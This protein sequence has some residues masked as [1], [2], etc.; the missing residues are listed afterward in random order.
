MVTKTEKNIQ[1]QKIVELMVILNNEMEKIIDNIKYNE[2]LDHYSE[3]IFKKTVIAMYANRIYGLLITALY[4]MNSD[5]KTELLMPIK[6]YL[7]SGNIESEL[8]KN[9]LNLIQ[10]DNAGNKEMAKLIMQA[11]ILPINK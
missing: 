6:L 9:L 4:I 10:V 5:N 1:I 3:K 2:A 7:A 11:D 8:L